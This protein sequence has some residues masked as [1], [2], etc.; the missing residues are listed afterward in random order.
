MPSSCFSGAVAQCFSGAVA[1]WR[2]T[3]ASPARV[4][5]Q[6]KCGS[7][8]SPILHLGGSALETSCLPP[9]SRSQSQQSEFSAVKGIPPPQMQTAIGTNRYPVPAAASTC[10]LTRSRTKRHGHRATGGHQS[11]RSRMRARI[12]DKRPD[13]SKQ[14]FIAGCTMV[15]L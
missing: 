7:F 8:S 6:N 14:S 13:Q 2:R 4:A 15:A 10:A 1:Q 9:R 12:Q 3:S 5:F 11:T